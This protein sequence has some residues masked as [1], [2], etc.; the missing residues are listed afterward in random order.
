VQSVS[1]DKDCQAKG[2]ETIHLFILGLY[3]LEITHSH[4]SCQSVIQGVTRAES[5]KLLE[6]LYFDG[7]SFKQAFL[8]S[9]KHLGS[10]RKSHLLLKYGQQ[11]VFFHPV[12]SYI[13]LP[14]ACKEATCHVTGY[15]TDVSQVI[16]GQVS[17]MQNKFKCGGEVKYEL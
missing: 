15:H 4:F 10:F 9:I 2:I 12:S 13:G 3:N 17:S 5:S 14:I 6:M 11:F 1:P 7:P 8:K 16:H